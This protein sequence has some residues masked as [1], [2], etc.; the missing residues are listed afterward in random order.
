MTYP[1]LKYT[2]KDLR[3][4]AASID[5]TAEFITLGKIPK[6]REQSQLLIQKF[7]SDTML[8]RVSCPA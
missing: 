6:E 4:I 1:G 2:D 3:S 7:N 5:L 8:L